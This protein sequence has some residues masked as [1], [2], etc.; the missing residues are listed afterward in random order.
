VNTC[1]FQDVVEADPP[2]GPAMNTQDKKS[3]IVL[4][5]PCPGIGSGQIDFLDLAEDGAEYLA[6]S[7]VF[8][9]GDPWFESLIPLM[10]EVFG[11][12]AN[13][14]VL[15]L[16]RVYS[17]DSTSLMD[18]VNLT[19]RI[20]ALGGKLVLANLRPRVRSVI[21]VTQ[22]DRFFAMFLSLD[23]GIAHLKA[24]GESDN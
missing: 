1:V 19:R 7:H 17:V 16:E 5:R 10:E 14:V 24:Q 6:Y 21:D 4:I 15:D 3:R 18:L 23:D 12:A 9:R 11:T 22:L 2:E 8:P 13:H 20:D